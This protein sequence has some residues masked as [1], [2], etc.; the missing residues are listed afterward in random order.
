MFFNL[1]FNLSKLIL[2]I[3]INQKIIKAIIMQTAKI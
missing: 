3:F 2:N 1:I